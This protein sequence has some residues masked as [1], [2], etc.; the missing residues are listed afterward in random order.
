MRPGSNAVRICCRRGRP[1]AASTP[2]HRPRRSS[3]SPTSGPTIPRRLATSRTRL[4][5]SPREVRFLAR[6]LSL[7][8]D[9]VAPPE[10]APDLQPEPPAVPADELS[11]AR[12]RAVVGQEASRP[13]DH[14]SG[15]YVV[16]T[17]VPRADQTAL[18]IQAA[19]RQV[20]ELVSAPP[21]NREQL[22]VTVPDCPAP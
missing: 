6:S 11:V 22:A 19:L 10:G 18:L 1:R 14:R 15:P 4:P 9:V 17:L 5:A 13:I 16:A 2:S 8:D 21:R 20:G 3:G 12:G 7:D